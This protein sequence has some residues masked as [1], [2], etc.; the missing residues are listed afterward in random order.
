VSADR[1]T[2][3]QFRARLPAEAYDEI[4]ERAGADELPDFDEFYR[5]ELKTRPD[6]T[7]QGAMQEY[8]ALPTDERRPEPDDPFCAGNVGAICDG[9]FVSE[10]QPIG[11]R[12]RLLDLPA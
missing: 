1:S 5:E 9:D 4:I 12:S 7:R 10:P 8:Q 2:E 3:E 6:L 11:P